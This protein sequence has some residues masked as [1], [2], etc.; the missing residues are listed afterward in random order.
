MQQ[1]PSSTSTRRPQ[2]K[3][4]QSGRLK[5]ASVRQN[6]QFLNR[7]A[8]EHRQAR[9][10]GPES[11][12]AISRRNLSCAESRRC[13]ERIF[14]DDTDR[15]PVGGC[16]GSCWAH[17]LHN[18]NGVEPAPFPPPRVGG[19]PRPRWACFSFGTFT[20]GCPEGFRGYLGLEDAIPLGLI[21]PE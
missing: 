18:P 2:V 15:G 10:P 6:R 14:Q 5:K 7:Q 11:Q 19:Q 1:T 9:I 13:R 20:Q 17:V 12:S 3:R 16:L 8:L 21:T 4:A